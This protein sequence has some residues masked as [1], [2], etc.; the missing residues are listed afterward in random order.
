MSFW[1]SSDYLYKIFFCSTLNILSITT[2]I[3]VLSLLSIAK[4]KALFQFFNCK[5][6][7]TF[8]T[9]DF[10]CS[11]NLS[12]NLNFLCLIHFFAKLI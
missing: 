8:T 6:C 5:Y 7:G 11:K 2:L 3:T 10:S 1:F 4:S 12:D 9:M